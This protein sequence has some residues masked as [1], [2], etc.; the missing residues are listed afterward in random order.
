MVCLSD[1]TSTYRFFPRLLVQAG[2]WLAPMLA[3][4]ATQLFNMRTMYGE[5][6]GSQGG[7]LG[8]VGFLTG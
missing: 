6:G 7:R 5:G 2:L 3:G 4:L 1:S 8:D